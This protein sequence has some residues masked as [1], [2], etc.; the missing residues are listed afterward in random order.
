MELFA[1]IQ[2]LHETPHEYLE[3]VSPR[4]LNALLDGYGAVDSRIVRVMRIV[5]DPLSSSPWPLGPV[6]SLNACARVYL[7]EPNLERGVAILLKRFKEVLQTLPD[8]NPVRGAGAGRRF[9]DL[10]AE[11]VRQ[12]PATVF[13]V[14]GEATPS[15]VYH[16]SIGF[17][18]AF[19]E[20][21]AEGARADREQIAQFT[22]W[23]QRQYSWEVSVPWHRLMRVYEGE[24]LHGLNSFVR[25]WDEFVASPEG[26]GLR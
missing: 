19:A 12:G 16:Y 18:L 10:V 20:F 15:W 13:S 11:A 8:K 14:F 3:V 4:Y 17:D 26:A 9:V 7:A 2:R 21:D 5:D 22:Q 6:A 24:S 23:L 1:L 25:S